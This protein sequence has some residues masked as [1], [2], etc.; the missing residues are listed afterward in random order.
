M[1]FVYK[2]IMKLAI[3]FL[4]ECLFILKEMPQI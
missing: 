2:V 3:S 1:K 4:L